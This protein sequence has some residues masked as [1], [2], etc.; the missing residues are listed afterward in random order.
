MVLLSLGQSCMFT[1]NKP[2]Q[3]LPIIAT[4]AHVNYVMRQ[5]NQHITVPY[6]CLGRKLQR[7]NRISF[8]NAPQLCLGYNPLTFAIIV[9]SDIM[10][11]RD[12]CRT[13]KLNGM[14]EHSLS[15]RACVESFEYRIG[16]LATFVPVGSMYRA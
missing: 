5:K 4:F 14:I 16:Y 2:K 12:Y 11:M 6:H 9:S 13:C 7:G 1:L 3:T 10:Y 8:K 15:D